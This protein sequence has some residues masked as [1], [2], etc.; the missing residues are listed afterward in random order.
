MELAWRLGIIPDDVARMAVEH[1]LSEVVTGDIPTPLKHA[2]V[3]AGAGHVIAH[4]PIED[5]D[6]VASIVKFADTMEALIYVQ[7]WGHTKQTAQI[8]DEMYQR[9][10]KET[11]EH[12]TVR[13]HVFDIL[14]EALDD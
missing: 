9:L 12:E 10:E 13:K 14:R 3:G 5:G 4:S 7:K 11:A 6:V 8:A 1:D 2:I